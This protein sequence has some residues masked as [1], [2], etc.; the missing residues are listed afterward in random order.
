M[1]FAGG[2]RAAH[3]V[4]ST[5]S[6]PFDFISKSEFKDN[7]DCY[8]E[9]LKFTTASVTT[10]SGELIKGLIVERPDARPTL[11]VVLLSK[12]VRVEEGV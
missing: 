7:W 2:A 11:E 12:W 3:I 1:C 4:D 6:E 9:D 5:Y 8:P 10:R